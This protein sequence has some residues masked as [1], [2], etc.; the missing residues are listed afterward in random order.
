MWSSDSNLQALKT[1]NFNRTYA[2]L[3]DATKEMLIDYL[4][5]KKWITQTKHELSK[6]SA[7][8]IK[9]KTK[10][11][12]NY[13]GHAEDIQKLQ[14]R[15]VVEKKQKEQNQTLKREYNK[16][17]KDFN[18]KIGEKYFLIG[19]TVW[20]FDEIRT[21]SNLDLSEDKFYP[22]KAKI[23]DK[24]NQGKI[25]TVEILESRP[26]YEAGGHFVY[27]GQ[28][29]KFIFDPITCMWLREGLT[30]E[31]ARTIGPNNKSF[32]F[33]L[34]YTRQYLILPGS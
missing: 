31:V 28:V 2:F 15:I 26:W 17:Q 20:I 18:L 8:V 4:L 33:Q 25:I 1:V 29:I 10:F 22:I 12:L 34:S 7:E 21:D 14:D 3:N 9:E 6:E 16:I 13:Y 30:P 23:I 5:K 27:N 32:Y 19:S 24:E 11:F